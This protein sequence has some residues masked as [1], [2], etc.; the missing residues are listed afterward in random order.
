[1]NAASLSVQKARALASNLRTS[2]TS[3][4]GWDGRVDRDLVREAQEIYVLAQTVT[5]RHI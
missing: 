2:R 1:M 4:R 3:G 5:P